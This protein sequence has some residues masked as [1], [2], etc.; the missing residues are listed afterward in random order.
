MIQ[1][2][3]ETLRKRQALS[4][5]WAGLV[6]AWSV[7]RTV[8]IWAALRNYGFNPW[9]YLAI[10]LVCSATDGITTP[11]MVMRFVDDRYRSAIK[12]GSVSL[13][14]YVVPDIYIFV[15][16]RT[17][18]KKVVVILCIVILAMLGLAVATIVH[19]VRKGREQRA[20]Y[21]SMAAASGRA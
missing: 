4:R 20:L 8:V 21:E 11:R 16:T 14:A 3:A 7:I 9:I 1:H 6:I 10:D 15:G 12:W 5:A 2:S 13:V 19:K 18:P 17:L